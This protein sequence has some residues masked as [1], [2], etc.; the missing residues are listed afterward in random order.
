VTVARQKWDMVF[1]AMH[2]N[3]RAAHKSIIHIFHR[4]G[5][6]N[7]L[8]LTHFSYSVNFVIKVGGLMASAQRELL[9]NGGSGAEPPAGS[10]GRAPCQGIRGTNSP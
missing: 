3:L 5:S 9:Y 7:A 2:Q 1:G 10:R 6:E 4:N 8:M